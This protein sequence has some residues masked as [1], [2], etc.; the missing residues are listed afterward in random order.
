MR[1]ILFRGKRLDNGEW[2]Y[3]GYHYEH[4]FS[5]DNEKHYITV[6]ETYGS[7]T[8][9]EF[10]E[11]NATTIGQFTDVFD[12]YGNKI[13]EGD[14]IRV[15]LPNNKPKRDF[16]ARALWDSAFIGFRLSKYDYFMN[17]NRYGFEIIGNIH[18]NKELLK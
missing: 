17:A 18:D 11:V 12:K 15:M 4:G 9:N 3:G 6:Y 2:V 16:I 7:F 14:I 10:V 5:K 13:F 1:E 8:Y